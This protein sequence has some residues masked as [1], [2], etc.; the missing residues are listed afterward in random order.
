MQEAPAAWCRGG[1]LKR[2]SSRR[3]NRRSR[4]EGSDMAEAQKRLVREYE[5]IYLIKADTPDDQVEEIKERLRG[6]RI[7]TD[8]PN[9]RLLYPVS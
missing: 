7:L 1:S 4:S 8:M 3:V 6:A 2:C 5:T 9:V